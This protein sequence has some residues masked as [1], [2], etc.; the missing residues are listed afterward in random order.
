MALTGKMKKWAEAYLVTLNK[1]E[2]SRR[3]GYGGTDADL[4]NI[5]YQNYRKLEVQ[6]YLKDRLAAICMPANEVLA[7]LSE[8]ASADMSD[9]LHFEDGIKLPFLDLKGAAEK[10]LLRL[11]KKFKYNDDGRPE[12]ELYDAQAALV[13]LGKAHGIFDKGPDGSDDKPFVIKVVY[14]N[15]DNPNPTEPS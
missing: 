14:A 8:Q 1:T 6:E 3:A 11:V 9:F 2:A 7:R 13:H 4:S 12:I 5:G 15:R 10:G